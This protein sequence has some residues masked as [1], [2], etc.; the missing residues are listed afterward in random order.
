MIT[1]EKIQEVR[2]LLKQ[3]VSIRQIYRITG[4]HR[5]AINRLKSGH[6][7]SKT[8]F[9]ERI[10]GEVRNVFAEPDTRCPVCG[11]LVAMPCL[12]CAVRTQHP[13]PAER[14]KESLQP[15]LTGG[16]RHGGLHRH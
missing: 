6:R 13:V 7:P 4:V 8:Y 10:G 11:G 15:Q 3:G 5:Q 14:I 16:T 9:N 2:A 1:E 12:L